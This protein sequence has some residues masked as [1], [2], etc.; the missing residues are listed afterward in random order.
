MKYV[1]ISAKLTNKDYIKFLKDLSKIVKDNSLNSPVKD[2]SYYKKNQK[3]IQ[4]IAKK[5]YEDYQT[6]EIKSVIS[7][8]NEKINKIYGFPGQIPN[9]AAFLKKQITKLTSLD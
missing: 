8:N 3:K 4:T 1:E 7:W 5:I 9:Y 6:D 2:E